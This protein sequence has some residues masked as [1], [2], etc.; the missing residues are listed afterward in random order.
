M[1]G[2]RSSSFLLSAS[3]MVQ[4]LSLFVEQLVNEELAVFPKELAH[5]GMITLCGSAPISTFLDFLA[6]TDVAHSIPMNL[7][8]LLHVAMAPVA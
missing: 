6:E 3:T 5:H 2:Y 7:G 8:L 1:A 4:S